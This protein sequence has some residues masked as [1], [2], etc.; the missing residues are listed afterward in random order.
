M[1]KL[2][3]ERVNGIRTGFW[4]A[5]KK[6][7][8]VQKLG[9]IEHQFDELATGICEEVCKHMDDVNMDQDTLTV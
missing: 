5:A 7:D 9:A 6:E 3:H 2:T 4:S 1:P 8:L